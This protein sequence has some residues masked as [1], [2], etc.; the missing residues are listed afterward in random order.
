MPRGRRLY[1]RS[2]VAPCVSTVPHRFQVWMG[3]MGIDAALSARVWH[4]LTR[5]TSPLGKQVWWFFERLET[6]PV[7]HISTQLMAHCQQVSPQQWVTLIETCVAT[8]HLTRQEA[9]TLTEH[10]LACTAA[11][12]HW[13]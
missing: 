12:G 1:A 5:D 2:F 11:D 13:K 4:G 9:N 3:L 10:L 7:E 6:R 8:G